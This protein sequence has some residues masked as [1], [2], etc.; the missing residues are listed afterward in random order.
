M[1]LPIS[2]GHSPPACSSSGSW[3]RWSFAGTLGAR[4]VK[5]PVVGLRTETRLL[6]K[7]LPASGVM[8]AGFVL[9]SV[10]N[11]IVAEIAFRREVNLSFT[12]YLKVEPLITLFN[13]AIGILWLMW[14]F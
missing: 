2:I 10:A 4:L 5:A 7:S 13:L 6:R 8:I 11:L 3:W 9:G 14:V 1:V 12:E